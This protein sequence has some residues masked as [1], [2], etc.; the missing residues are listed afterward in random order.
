[1]MESRHFEAL[2]YYFDAEENSDDNVQEND[3]YVQCES[4][5]SRQ[6]FIEDEDEDDCEDTIEDHNDENED[7]NGSL[8]GLLAALRKARPAIADSSMKT[9]NGSSSGDAGGSKKKKGILDEIKQLW[10]NLE[11]CVVRPPRSVYNSTTDLLGTPSFRI[12][13][14]L[15]RRDDFIVM[16]SK[17]MKLVASHY[18]HHSFRPTSSCNMNEREEILPPCVIY[19]HGNSGSRC[20][21]SQAA[22]LLLQLGISVCAFDFSGSGLSDGNYVT[23]GQNET[24][25]VEAIVNYIRSE[26]RAER[27][28]LW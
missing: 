14:T 3:D 23:L 24:C 12:A 18:V 22:I 6:S 5:I 13:G 7:P 16:N 27:I 4:I 21:A 28:G 17:G 11:D 1:M 26:G 20:D 25:D 2:T 19:C 9:T 15:Y 10:M 8:C